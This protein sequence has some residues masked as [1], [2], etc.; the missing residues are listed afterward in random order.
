MSEDELELKILERFVD[1]YKIASTEHGDDKHA[2]ELDM[3]D[4]VR[5]LTGKDGVELDY[6]TETWY[7]RL[8]L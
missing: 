7:Q 4:V 6:E 5:E 1:Q 8:Q 2:R 3:R